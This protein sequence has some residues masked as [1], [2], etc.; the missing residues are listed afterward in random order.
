M[1]MNSKNESVGIFIYKNIIN[2]LTI[3]VTFNY[4]FTSNYNQNVV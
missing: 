4:Y 3:N 2:K 1:S